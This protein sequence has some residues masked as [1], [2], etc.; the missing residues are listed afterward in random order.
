M[1]TTLVVVPLEGHR[2]TDADQAVVGRAI[3]VTG[4]EEAVTVVLLGP[5][6][7]AEAARVPGSGHVL[8]EGSGR[9][10]APTDPRV[11]RAIEITQPDV[12]FVPASV[13][14][15][16]HLPGIAG[17]AGYALVPGVHD[18]SVSEHGLQAVRRWARGAAHAVF[19]VPS[20]AMVSFTPD[21]RRSHAAGSHEVTALDAPAVAPASPTAPRELPQLA[22]ADRVIGIGRGVALAD[23]LGPVRELQV[24]LQAGLAASR[25]AIEEKQ[26]LGTDKVGETGA[27]IA[28]DLY[29]ALGL[30]GASQHMSGVVGAHRIVAVES[31]GRAPI[32][33]VA[34]A[35]F[36][37]PLEDFLPLL[38]DAISALKRGE[39]FASSSA[40]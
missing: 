23:A 35:T 2:I 33:D 21:F 24:S 26:A 39:A 10:L 1:I 18:V 30:S 37:A 11:L 40:R 28:P 5:G 9:T 12:V 34:D 38:L 19:E 4:A 15:R 14:S 17:A 22:V 7:K 32:A 20:K 25:Q 6:A 36:V 8:V 29:L 13:A 31:S 27:A 16:R 3:R